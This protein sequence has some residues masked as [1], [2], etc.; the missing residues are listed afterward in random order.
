MHA[1]MLPTLPL[2]LLIVNI[3]GGD[4]ADN[5]TTVDDACIVTLTNV[6]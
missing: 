4:G 6:F 2:E 1:P 3:G 5:C